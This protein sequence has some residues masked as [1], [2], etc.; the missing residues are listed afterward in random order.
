MKRRTFFAM[1]A[2]SALVAGCSF[3]DSN[4]S[5]NDRLALPDDALARLA[6]FRAEPKF[7]PE[8]ISAERPLGYVGYLPPEERPAA[9]AA[10][11]SLIDRVMAI[12][13]TNPR[14][15]LVL[16]EFKSSFEFFRYSDT[17][18][19]ERFCSYLEDIMDAVGMKSSD[20]VINKLMYGF[21]LPS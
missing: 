13:K 4:P 10:L 21:N 1:F 2:T 3:A 17:E 6:K 14:K 12:V 19:R 11:N 20:G 7:G 8:D 9:E 16:N 18:D 5:K 15:S